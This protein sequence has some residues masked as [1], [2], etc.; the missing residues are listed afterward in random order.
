MAGQEVDFRAEQMN[1]R[2]E[3]SLTSMLPDLLQNGSFHQMKPF[4]SAATIANNG[5]PKVELFDVKTDFVK[6]NSAD[7][8]LRLASKYETGSELTSDRELKQAGL[9]PKDVKH[10]VVN[11]GDGWTEESTSVKYPSGIEV[12]VTGRSK[13][14]S[15]GRDVVSDPEATVKEPL[16]KGYRK[17]KDGAIFDSSNRKVAQINEDGTVTIKVG[18]DY[19]TQGPAGVREE[20]VF[21]SKT[22]SGMIGRMKM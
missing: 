12:T 18:K 15:N 7:S 22:G 16:P 5:F 1:S 14:M 9:N 13:H 3:S 10:K 21:E 19:V 17:D 2:Q 6:S 8:S 11:R 4:H 20:T